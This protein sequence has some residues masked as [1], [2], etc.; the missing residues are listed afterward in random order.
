MKKSTTVKQIK[1]EP[2]NKDFY[3]RFKPV[4]SFFIITGI[5]AQIISAGTES[6]SIFFGVKQQLVNFP[7]IVSI[8]LAILAVILGAPAIELIG[9]RGLQVCTRTLVNIQSTTIT[10]WDVTLFILVAGVSGTLW[11]QSYTLSTQGIDKSFTQ[12]SDKTPT[13]D[14]TTFLKKHNQLLAEINTRFDKQKT[15]K[16][17][18]HLTEY[19]SAEQGYDGMIDEEK[20]LIAK[21]IRK[22]AK[23]EKWAK[24]HRDKHKLKK[25]KI[26]QEKADALIVIAKNQGLKIDRIE[27]NR[28]LA[29]QQEKNRFE[30]EVNEAKAN[31]AEN[32]N[33]EKAN[34][35]FWGGLFANLV[36]ILIIIAFLCI[37]TEEIFNK[38]AGIKIEYVDAETSPTP[39][40]L[41][42]MGI[43]NS[44]YNIGLWI[45]SFFHNYKNIASFNWLAENAT[46]RINTNLQEQFAE[47]KVKYDDLKSAFNEEVEKIRAKIENKFRNNIGELRLKITELETIN[48]NLKQQNEAE[49][50]DIKAQFTQETEALKIKHKQQIAGYQNS[51]SQDVDHAITLNN[52]QH[53]RELEA[54]K[55]QFA[56]ENRN[57]SREFAE[58]AENQ[59]KE[60]DFKTA[61]QQNKFAEVA[62]NYESKIA[63]SKS[64]FAQKEQVYKNEIADLKRN[65]HIEI[66]DAITKERAKFAVAP[67]KKPQIKGGSPADNSGKPN[68]SSGNKKIGR[69]ERNEQITTD[70]FY[71]FIAKG[72]R[73][74]KITHKMVADT[75]PLSER[76]VGPIVNKLR[77]IE[78]EKTAKNKP[79]G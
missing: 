44:L 61:E 74:D 32:H 77:A 18:L 47:M 25:A 23:G 6:T 36:G 29:I 64:E 56:S 65:K 68:P 31:L 33:T 53:K 48:R 75:T 78:A 40:G 14:E 63:A 38:G 26:I 3:N 58:K 73:Y 20:A 11:Y 24:S 79:K 69:K 51:N 39:L 62:Q 13:L 9:R 27:S 43:C 50:A 42:W 4:I 37:V 5:L 72:H 22:A 52:Q 71:E 19:L 49:I 76:T 7:L 70:K 10:L 57:L 28:S 34:A 30:T 67:K 1:T 16:E 66:A 45:A 17:T 46:N 55:Q 35:A 12:N 41:M 54:Q 8:P 2:T 21:F 15:T 60:F 59:Q